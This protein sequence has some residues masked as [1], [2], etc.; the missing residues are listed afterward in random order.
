MAVQNRRETLGAFVTVDEPVWEPP[1]WPEECPAVGTYNVPYEEYRKWPALNAGALKYAVH[2]SAK[3]MRAAIDGLFDSDSRDRKFG[4][5]IHCRLLEPQEFSTRF[6]LAGTCE[7]TIKSGARKG[8]PCGKAAGFYDGKHWFCGMHQKAHNGA[9]EPEEY[10]DRAEVERCERIAAAVKAHPIVKLLRQHGGAEV[11]LVWEWDGLPCKARLDKFITGAD[12]PDTIID[13]KKC[14]SCK[15]DDHSLQTSI[16]Q[17]GWDIQAA[18]YVAGAEKITGTRP[19]FAFVFMEDNEPFD[20][21][22]VWASR[23]MLAVG[24][25]K[26]DRG[27]AIYKHAIATGKWPGYCEQIEEFYPAN[28]ELRQYGVTP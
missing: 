13:L 4:R 1:P 5:A 26:V 17:Y 14:Q 22:P 3:H 2:V 18:F 25:A 7:E 28:F 20:V 19:H 6:L 24:Q 16:R 12:C 9:S 23:A 10:V 15:A 11:S 8:E 21:R 27:F